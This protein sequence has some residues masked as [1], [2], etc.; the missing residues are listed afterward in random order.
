MDTPQLLITLILLATVGM[1]LWGRWRHDMVALGA[2]LACVVAG[3]VSADIAFSGF[4]HPAVI[5]VACVLVLSQALQSSGAVDA[6]LRHALPGNAGPALTIAA[7]TG[8]AA[9]LSG[10]MNNVGALALLMPVALQVANRQGLPPGRVLMP[11]AFGSILGG[12]TT[13]IGTPPNLIVSGF[14]AEAGADS[15]AMFDFTPVGLAVAA[16]GVLFVA[17]VGWRLV[18][19]RQRA[20]ADSFEVGAYVTEARVRDGSKVVGLSLH[21]IDRLLEDE[22]AQIIGLIRNEMR[23]TPPNPYRKVRLDD[24]LVIEAEAA[25]LP[26]ALSTLGLKLE[27]AVRPAAD[28]EQGGEEGDEGSDGDLA[29]EVQHA[30][31][32]AK[33]AADGAMAT[34]DTEHSADEEA[35]ARG[36][37]KTGAADEIRLMELAVLPQSGLSERSASDI[38]LRTRYGINLLAISRQGARSMARLRTTP[39]RAGDVLLMQGPPETIL[40]FASDNGC[41]PLAE[42]TLRIP[43]RRKAITASLVMLLAV[44]GAAFGLLPAAVAFAGGVLASMALRTI[45]LRS[46]YT[47]ID[48]PVIVLLAALIPVAGAMESTGTARLLAGFLLEGVA[49]GN[50]A[51]ALVLVLLVTMSLSDLMNNA[52]TAAVM[53]PIAIGTASLLG[54]SADPFLMAVAVGASCAFLT[55]IGHQNN[56][57]ILGPGGFRFG[58]YW[59]LGLPVQILVVLVS[60]PMLLWVWPL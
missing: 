33:A 22:D 16:V 25:A 29:P 14:R 30:D 20:D 19:A 3:L 45:P 36:E 17:L 57:L 21:D 50:A 52:A 42:R 2:L 9:L 4:G 31:A 7:I 13:M 55:P 34:A 54:A 23:L 43:N 24:I 49:Q 32:A 10:F 1:F 59:R 35:E 47:A 56:T 26:A 51:V 28:A 53:C 40:E 8:I 11:L 38:Q 12:M 48:W 41:V 58:D 60:V 44:A 27:E 6:L 46:V 18:P 37:S 15:F 39:L 5:T